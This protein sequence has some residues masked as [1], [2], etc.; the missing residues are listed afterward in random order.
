MAVDAG[1]SDALTRHGRGRRTP[2]CRDEAVA[3]QPVV[4]DGNEDVSVAA[5]VVET[6]VGG[7]ARWADRFAYPRPAKLGCRTYRLDR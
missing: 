5:V 1:P 7:N 6:G 3:D 4:T 2:V